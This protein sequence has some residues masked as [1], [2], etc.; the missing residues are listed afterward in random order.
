[1]A[2]YFLHLRDET[3]IALDEEEVEFKSMESLAVVYASTRTRHD[4]RRRSWRA[5]WI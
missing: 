1:M 3:D 2:R 4:E 5:I